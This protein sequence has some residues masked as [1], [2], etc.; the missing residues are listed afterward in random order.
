MNNEPS[1]QPTISPTKYCISFERTMGVAISPGTSHS[2]FLPCH[3]SETLCLPFQTHSSGR[4]CIFSL[5]LLFPKSYR[6]V[7][8][9]IESKCRPMFETYQCYRLKNRV[10]EKR[11]TSLRLDDSWTNSKRF[12]KFFLKLLPCV[13]C[14]DFLCSKRFRKPQN[15]FH[16][17]PGETN[18]SGVKENVGVHHLRLENQSNKTDEIVHLPPHWDM[19]TRDS[20]SHPKHQ[21]RLSSSV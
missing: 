3:A 10:D 12:S 8:D 20:E 4:N 16:P 5:T 7:L 19:A 2:H 9:E 15:C 18:T 14:R 1:E 21:S 13:I 6:Q 11:V 17:L